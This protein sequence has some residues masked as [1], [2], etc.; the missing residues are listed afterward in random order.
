MNEVIKVGMA[1]LNVVTPPDTIRTSGLGS[2]V[3]VILYD[4]VTLISGM[5]HVMLPSSALCKQATP[6]PAKYADTA[7]PAL[8]KKLESKGA[9]IFSLKA[10]LAGG[11]QMFSFSTGND[12][13]RIGPRN[14]EAVKEKLNE[15]R[16]PI[17]AED[18]GGKSGRTIEF[19]PLS[20][21]L[22]IRTV[23]QGTKEI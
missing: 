4:E 7:I 23:N 6:N 20:K 18:V 13:M 2:C 1:D 8:I 19:N 5:A 10:K 14:V 17:L 3:G 21:K 16:I 15:L 11:A 9:K 22:Q 12:M